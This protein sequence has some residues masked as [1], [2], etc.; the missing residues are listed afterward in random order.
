MER[1]RSVEQSNRVAG[2]SGE[3]S[4]TSSW[5]IPLT[6]AAF[7]CAVTL[8][9]LQ[10]FVA[11]E[12]AQ[13]DRATRAEAA[14]VKE[15]IA[16]QMEARVLA[17]VRMAKRW[18][19][20]GQPLMRHWEADARLLVEHQGGYQAIGWVDPSY[21]VRWIAPREG[22]ERAL[23]IYT[24]HEER[25]R[26][27]QDTATAAGVVTMSRLT[28]LAQGGKGFVVYIP[29]FHEEK[30][31]GLLTGGFRA[32]KLFGT[33]LHENFARGYSITVLDGDEELYSRNPMAPADAKFRH[34]AELNLYGVTWRVRVSPTPALIAEHRSRLPDATL[35]VGLLTAVLLAL[36]IRFAQTA[37]AR[38]REATTLNDGLEAEI[39]ERRSIEE[40]LRATFQR[41]A[42]HVENSPLGVVEWDAQMCIRQWSAEAENIFGWRADEVIGKEIGND[43]RFFH[44]DD[45]EEVG[46]V[47]IKMFGGVTPRAVFASRN[48]TKDGDVV[49]CQWFNSAL[50]DDNGR[51]VS[52]MSLGLDVTESKRAATALRASEN[53]LRELC[54]IA[55]NTDLDLDGKIRG[56]IET[57]CEQ[58]RLQTGILARIEDDVYEVM[59]SIA[60]EGDG[61]DGFICHA[62]KTIC[63]EVMRADNSIAIEHVGVSEWRDHPGYVDF[64][65]ETYIGAPVRVGGRSYGA[66]C[67]TSLEPRAEQFT[68]ADKEFLRL[69]A[70]WIGGKLEQR[71]A[72]EAIQ[73]VN[74][75]LAEARDQALDSARLKSEFL[76]NMSHEIRTPM[77]GVVGMSD[78][79]LNTDL[80]PEQSDYARTIQTSG[81]SLL[82]IINDILDFSKVEAGKMQFE[83]VDF[84]LRDTIED[85]IESFAERALAKRL[86]LAM[87]FHADVPVALCGDPGRLRQVMTNLIGNA[88]KFTAKGEVVVRVTCEHETETDATLR[89]GVSDTGIGISEATRAL[90][91]QPFSQADG[92][93]TRDYG[94]T[95]LGLAISKQLVGIMRGEIAVESTP[96]VG[97]TFYFTARFAKQPAE[98]GNVSATNL[99]PQKLRGLCVL[100]VDDNETNRRIL[101]EQ[102][103]GWGMIPL[104]VADGARAIEE[105]RNAARRGEPFTLALLDLQ[106]PG[107]DGFDLAR[108]IKNDPAVAATRLV[109]MPSFSRRGHGEE[110]RAAG[111]AAY[112]TKPVRQSHLFECLTIVVGDIEHEIGETPNVKSRFVTRHTLK[113]KQTGGDDLAPRDRHTIAPPDDFRERARGSIL[114][115][116]DNEVNQKVVRRQMEELGFSAHVVSNGRIALEALAERSY[117]LVLMDCQMPEMDG[118]EAT[119]EIRRREGSARRTP[120]VAMTAHAMRG[121]RERCLAAGMDDYLPKPVRIKDLQETL[122]RWQPSTRN[123][124]VMMNDDRGLTVEPESLPVDMERLRDAS[125]GDEELQEELI[126]IYLD[127]MSE[128]I[129]ALKAAVASN[130]RDEVK[131]IAHTLAGGSATCGMVAVVPLLRELEQN[132]YAVSLAEALP[133]IERIEQAVERIKKFLDVIVRTENRT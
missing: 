59:Q 70:Q 50:A 116:E 108:E 62:D 31:A 91:F 99:D 2:I 98:I 54:D 132:E 78:L 41:L 14:S 120:I 88:I 12:R 69:M 21:H 10:A 89:F 124:K 55:S 133:L 86:E 13:L 57:G 52:I 20:N 75:E 66:L 73:R 127:Q 6:A 101:V 15:A 49:H 64:K 24:R 130:S 19:Q 84:D 103:A 104:A 58:L 37:R 94:G 18:E 35:L 118:Y 7:V 36:T 128:N 33:L 71:E 87:L 46:D 90:L 45:A 26:V 102:T 126:E 8:L 61:F 95:G 32:P 125:S 22:N 53:R 23:D 97:S 72:Q 34:E 109:L 56:L 48:Y 1:N 65:L 3:R 111:V 112:L 80:T 38:A 17:L 47:V 85:T 28:E 82:T 39:A 83:E 5:S 106:M 11:H 63:R 68:T 74:R 27:P 122:L 42:S 105:L 76:A 29:I 115:A 25:K 96:G 9:L 100:I 114:I 79:L 30:F 81:D 51:L 4:R 123:V 121:D 119:A 107:M 67:F 131:R 110:A 40:R 43:F 60:T 16:T 92:S 77:N 129:V 44:E 117:D 113:R 93:T